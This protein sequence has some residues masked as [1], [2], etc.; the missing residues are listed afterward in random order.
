MYI[1]MHGW[2]HEILKG[3]YTCTTSSMS[4]RSTIKC[5][6]VLLQGGLRILLN[7]GPYYTNSN[8]HVYYIKALNVLL[9]DST[10]TTERIYYYKT[11]YVPPCDSI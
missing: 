2:L 5:L 1:L 7:A 11:I 3:M 8:I 4:I 9:K 6:Y 10:C